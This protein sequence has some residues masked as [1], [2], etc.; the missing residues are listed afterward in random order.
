MVAFLL[1]LQAKHYNPD[2]AINHLLKFLASFLSVLGHFCGF[3]AVLAANFPSSLY[4]LRKM[5]PGTHDF[6]RYVVCWKCWK[7]Y[8]YTECIVTRNTEK[9][10]KECGYIRF[11]NHPHLHLSCRRAFGQHLLRS[12][13]YV[14]GK[15]NLY[16]FKVY[17]YRSSK[18]SFQDLLLR[19]YVLENCQHWKSRDISGRLCDVYDGRVWKN[20]QVVSGK[21][22]LAAAFTSL[23]LM[24]NVDWFQPYKHT[25]HSVGVIYLTILN[26][27]RSLL[28]KRQNVVLLGL[29]P[30]PSE[31]KH[32]IHH[33]LNLK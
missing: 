8:H 5:L 9:L 6:T 10:S 22:F 25:V 11:L 30:G 15:K 20:F 18:S 26:L 31:P 4:R 32:D 14:S 2:N 33:V 16:P 1:Q 12:V 21:P 29:I 28:F 19:P 7:L 3:T 23:A 17:F 13:E 24:L 27:P